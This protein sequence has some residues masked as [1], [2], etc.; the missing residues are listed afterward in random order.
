MIL[1]QNQQVRGIK[2]IPTSNKIKTK[3]LNTMKNFGQVDCKVKLRGL[4][5]SEKD[6]LVSM[7]TKTAT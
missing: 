3:I 2:L 1:K 7:L 4:N 5:I 6:S